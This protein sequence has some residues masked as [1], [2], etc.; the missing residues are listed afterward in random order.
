[1]RSA[2]SYC[3]GCGVQDSNPAGTPKYSNMKKLENVPAKVLLGRVFST[4]LAQSTSR[5]AYPCLYRIIGPD[6]KG[7]GQT[8]IESRASLANLSVAL[9]HSNLQPLES[10]LQQDG[11]DVGELDG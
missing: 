6:T 3:C 8:H 7:C 11:S 1:M 2:C 10:V 5:R 4:P 9:T